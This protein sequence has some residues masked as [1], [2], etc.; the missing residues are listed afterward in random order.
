MSETLLANDA[1]K[2][3]GKG[4]DAVRYYEKTGRLKAE[5]TAGGIRLFRREDVKR[6]AR[7]LREKGR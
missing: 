7:E 6:L 1:A 3:L 4:P 2:I 5:R